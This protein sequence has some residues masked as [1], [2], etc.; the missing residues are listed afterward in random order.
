MKAKHKNAYLK[1][2]NYKP[3][4]ITL[5]QTAQFIAVILVIEAV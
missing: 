2:L 3:K 5:Y 1:L 4:A